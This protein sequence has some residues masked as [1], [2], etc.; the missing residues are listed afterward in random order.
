MVAPAQ[1]YELRHYVPLVGDQM[2][3]FERAGDVWLC[4]LYR[5]RKGNEAGGEIDAER[6]RRIGKTWMKSGER[7]ENWLRTGFKNPSLPMA[8]AHI[9]AQ[10]R[11]RVNASE[12]RAYLQGTTWGKGLPL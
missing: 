3:I 6:W 4:V 12:L 9:C 8:L 1:S 7:R 10:T 11:P 2:L 5:R